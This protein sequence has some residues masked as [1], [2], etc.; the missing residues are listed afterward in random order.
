MIKIEYCV[1]LVD[2]RITKKMKE[3]DMCHDKKVIGDFSTIEFTYP[4]TPTKK[5]INASMKALFKATGEAY[6]R[7]L[8]MDLPAIL[9]PNLMEL[10]NG[11]KS[12]IVNRK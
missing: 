7:C 6:V 5:Q 9:N 8:T 4:K 1:F 11:K 12:F 2:E 10:S 3:F